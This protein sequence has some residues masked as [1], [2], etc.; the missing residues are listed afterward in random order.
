M[1]RPP[2]HTLLLCCFSLLLVAPSTCSGQ[3]DRW[4]KRDAWQNVPGIFEAMDLREGSR[5]ADV[6]ARDGYLTVR[7]ARAVGEHGHVYAVDIDRK[8][9]EDLRDNLADEDTSRVTLIHSVPDDPML[10]EGTLDAV[11]V[12]NAYHE[13]RAYASMLDHIKA[14]LKPGGRLVLVEPISDRRRDASRKQQMSSHEIALHFARADLKE[15]GFEILEERD[16]FIERT[17]NSDEMWLLVGR[18]PE[19]E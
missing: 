1:L 19:A 5:V 9:L 14:A 13:F 4:V 3:N 16:P 17:H 7:L 8:A 12:V 15:A 11:V 6:G 18:R 2:V 10:P